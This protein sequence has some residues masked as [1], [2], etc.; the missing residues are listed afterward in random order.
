[1]KFTYVVHANTPPDDWAHSLQIMNMCK[2]FA[3]NGLEVTLVVPKRNLPNQKDFFEYYSIPKI[4][5]IVK[6]PCI[7]I[8]LRSESKV[9]YWIRFIS[10]YISARIYIWRNATEILY[11][12][13]LY[14]ACFF[15]GIVL[16]I[17]SFPKKISAFY[18]K[19]FLISSKIIVLTSFIKKRFSQVEVDEK[20][21]YVAPDGVD[22]EVFEHTVNDINVPKNIPGVNGEDFV[23]GYSGTLK[24]MGK[25]KGVADC[26]KSLQYLDNTYKFVV[27]GGEGIDIEYYKKMAEEL[28]V[29]IRTI[30]I[31]KV[32]YAEIPIY[33]KMCSVLVAPFPN[34]E[35]YAY[36]MSPL[37]IFEYMASKRPIITTTLPSLQ[38]VLTDQK[39][40]ILIPPS[41]P[42]ALSKA[43]MYLKENPEKARQ[44]AQ[45]AYE[46]VSEKYTWKKRAE[47]ILHFITLS[48][49]I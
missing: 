40:A 13:D 7:D 32:K 36:F 35:H 25:E 2:A 18:K 14:S 24:T 6:L 12:R 45:N 23:F 47:N 26:I 15:P 21:V 3:E 34:I 8:F 43:I 19:I 46:E 44:I 29:S 39:D 49:D 48:A 20:N 10:F 42:K 17:H 16:E 28:N 37:K 1:M 33:N 4:F 27:I 31:G 38:E 30:F 5:K 22:L 11:S 9:V 41:D